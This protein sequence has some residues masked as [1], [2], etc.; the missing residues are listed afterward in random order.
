MKGEVHVVQLVA[1]VQEE[2]AEGHAVQ[3]LFVEL[4]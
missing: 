3:L 2:Q 1:E 4:K